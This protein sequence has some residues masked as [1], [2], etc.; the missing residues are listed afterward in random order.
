MFNNISFIL[1]TLISDKTLI[2]NRLLLILSSSLLAL[3]L[4]II[5]LKRGFRIKIECL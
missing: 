1:Y 5:R 4:L 3:L 2:I